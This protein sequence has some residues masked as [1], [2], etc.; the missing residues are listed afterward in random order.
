[1]YPTLMPLGDYLLSERISHNLKPLRVKRGD[2]VIA[3][4]PRD[5]TVAVC[6]RVFGLEGDVVCVDP[7]GQ[8]G[9]QAQREWIKVPKGH[10]WLVGDNSSNSIDSRAYGP[11]PMAL[12]RGRVVA[13]VIPFCLYVRRR[14]GAE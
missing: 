2:M 10:V 6:K 5:P 12:L 7:T 1:M 3:V 14:I 11:V 8:H 9:W 13:R 4:S